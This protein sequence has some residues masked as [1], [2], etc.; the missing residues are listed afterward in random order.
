MKL[1]KINEND[2]HNM[3]SMAILEAINNYDTDFMDDDKYMSDEDIE[4]QYDDFSVTY[5][6]VKSSEYGGYNGTIELTFPNADDVDFNSTVVDNFTI[7]NDEATKFGFDNWYPQEITDQLKNIIRDYMIKNNIL[8]ES[9]KTTDSIISE[10]INKFINE[11]DMQSVEDFEE[12]TEK[13]REREGETIN[14]ADSGKIRSFLN[15]PY[16]NVIAVNAG[17][18]DNENIQALIEVLRSE[19]IQNFILKTSFH[20]NCFKVIILLTAFLKLAYAIRIM[21]LLSHWE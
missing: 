1:Y 6:E 3:V 21:D 16:V 15:N 11:A 20:C 10:V 4:S 5:I 14:T 18:E 8:V 9:V 13:A 19:E 2:L 12:R 17:D 7:Y